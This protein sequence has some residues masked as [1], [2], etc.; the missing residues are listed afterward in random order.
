MV[1]LTQF[2]QEELLRHCTDIVNTIARLLL[3]T[4]TSPFARAAASEVATRSPA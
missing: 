1:E 4:V 2:K 3:T